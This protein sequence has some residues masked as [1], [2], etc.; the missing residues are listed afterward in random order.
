[1]TVI[2]ITEKSGTYTK[3][4]EPTW[5]LPS[6]EVASDIAQPSSDLRM[7]SGASGNIY[8]R[9]SH[10]ASLYDHTELGLTDYNPKALFASMWSAS[11]ATLATGVVPAQGAGQYFGGMAT[12]NHLTHL[13]SP[14]LSDS[15]VEIGDLNIPNPYTPDIS[16]GKATAADYKTE[17]ETKHPGTNNSFPAKAGNPTSSGLVPN[18]L[19]L[20]AGDA[21]DPLSPHNTRTRLG[22]WSNANISTYGAWISE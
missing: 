15:T 19:D 9:G 11:G 6:S 13:D 5:A 20:S 16:A 18:S 4:P 10:M 7:G 12:T 2:N 21:D 8:G 17:F 3:A 22:G 1:M 14:T